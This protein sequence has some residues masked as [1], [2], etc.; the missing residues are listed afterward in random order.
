MEEEDPKEQVS[1]DMVESGTNK[2]EYG[3]RSMLQSERISRDFSSK[4]HIFYKSLGSVFQSKEYLAR[5]YVVKGSPTM[6][7][8]KELMPEVENIYKHRSSM[9]SVR[10]I[11]KKTLNITIADDDKVFEVKLH[12]ENISAP[13]KVKLHRNISEITIGVDN[14]NSSVNK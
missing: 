9:F 14:T 3:K 5:K 10:D 1:M 13:N 2:E 6:S 12:Y 11:E 4:K 7:E 8:I